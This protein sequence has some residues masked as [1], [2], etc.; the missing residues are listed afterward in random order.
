M[1]NF[2]I[3]NLQKPHKIPFKIL[4]KIFFLYQKSKYKFED[5]EN[6]QN[7]R[8]KN[9]NFDRIEGKK[10]LDF[11][12]KKNSFLVREM[13]S[14]HE[15]LF[16]SIS[17]SKKNQ[18]KKILEIGTFDGANAFLLSVLFKDSKIETIDLKS[19]EN[20]F[21]N[22][23]NRKNN[24]EKFINERNNLLKKSD[25]IK[26]EE[27][28]SV[29]LTFH[30]EKYDLIWIDGAHGYPVCCI[31]IVNSLKLLNREGMIMIDDVCL[32]SNN[33]DKMYTSIAAFETLKELEKNNIIKFN[34]IYKRLDADSNCIKENIKYVALV[35]KI[36]TGTI[37]DIA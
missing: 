36:Y 2:I 25:S 14:E 7:E 32:K 24:L 3:Y 26:F 23:Y 15:L 29:K 17:L 27:L 4:K 13:S 37:V 10:K 33:S 35:K 19:D 31:D 21:Q 28:N 6:E 8:F 30:K 34:L 1:K 20:D 9:L 11:I 16:S 22:F 18:I 5:F 12:K